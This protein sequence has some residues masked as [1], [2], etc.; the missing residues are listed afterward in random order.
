MQ[1]VVAVEQVVVAVGLALEQVVRVV[2]VKVV[3]PLRQQRVQL[4]Q[5]A[6]V[7]VVITTLLLL[8]QAAQA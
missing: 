2:V 4:T 5:G 6:V 1:A 8:Q 7:A 3:M